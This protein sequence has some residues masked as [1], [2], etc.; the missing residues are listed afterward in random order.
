MV[1]TQRT[2]GY[3]ERGRVGWK[4]YKGNPFTNPGTQYFAKLD[5]SEGGIKYDLINGK[6]V[7]PHNKLRRVI[8]SCSELP[9][10]QKQYLADDAQRNT[11]PND[12]SVAT[13]THNKSHTGLFILSAPI[14]VLVAAVVLVAVITLK[15]R[16]EL[17]ADK[18]S[19]LLD[20]GDQTQL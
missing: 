8:S 13:T 3:S 7:S 10:L 15:S 14:G 12:F 17:A 5:D 18:Y 9:N 19:T 6:P 1:S 2:W 20:E 16:R 11:R 4:G